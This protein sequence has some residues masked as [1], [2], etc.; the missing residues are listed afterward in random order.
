MKHRH[1]P[2][3]SWRNLLANAHH[4]GNLPARSRYFRS[5]AILSQRF[6]FSARRLLFLAALQHGTIR[7]RPFSKALGSNPAA[8]RADGLDDR[9]HVIRAGKHEADVEATVSNKNLPSLAS[10]VLKNRSQLRA[11]ATSRI[12]KSGTLAGFD[13]CRPPPY[14]RPTDRPDT[15]RLPAT[16][17]RYSDARLVVL[18]REFFLFSQPFESPT[19]CRF[20]KT[21]KLSIRQQKT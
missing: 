8:P 11:S 4:R 14:P 20:P 5:V 10:N 1:V 13:L 7:A 2:V 9:A 6:V 17:P 19:F 12:M 18:R 21:L 16:S 15:R 3:R